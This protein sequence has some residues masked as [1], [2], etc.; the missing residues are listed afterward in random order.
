MGPTGVSDFLILITVLAFFVFGFILG[1]L[2]IGR[3][4][5]FVMVG[6]TGGLAFGIR[7]FIL[8]AGLLLSVSNDYGANWVIIAFMGLINGVL[9]V[10]KKT[11]RCG[12]VCLSFGFSVVVLIECWDSSSLVHQ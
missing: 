12:L 6:I 10:F 2:E 3:R 9:L 4:S 1:L 5:G 7:I 11:E 8:K